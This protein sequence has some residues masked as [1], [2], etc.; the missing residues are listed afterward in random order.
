VTGRR[1]TSTVAPQALTLLNHPFVVEQAKATA[2]KLAEAKGDTETT[3]DH[4]YRL[5]LGRSPTD[6][7]RAVAVKYVHAKSDWAGLVHALFASA[8][9]RFVN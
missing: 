7:E 2:A 8:D 6:G 4:A 1:N 3:V 9:F 5:V